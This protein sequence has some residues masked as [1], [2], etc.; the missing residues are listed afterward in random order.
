MRLACVALHNNSQHV[1]G[2]GTVPF[3]DADPLGERE[4]EK[5]LSLAVVM[6]LLTLGKIRNWAKT[7]TL[8]PTVKGGRC[9]QEN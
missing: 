8:L 4:R 9:R 3:C 5:E 6:C 2:I 7:F 1:L